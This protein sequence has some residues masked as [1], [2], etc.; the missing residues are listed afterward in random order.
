M[1]GMFSHTNSF[2]ATVKLSQSE[3]TA[4]LTANLT[5]RGYTD[6]QITYN[7]LAANDWDRMSTSTLDATVTA[8]KNG[9][10]IS[11]PDEHLSGC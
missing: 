11:H 6:V 1:G 8:S 4:Y 7:Y 2:R 9:S 10:P 5:R 3:I